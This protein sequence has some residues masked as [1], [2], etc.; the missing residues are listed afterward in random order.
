MTKEELERLKR[1]LCKARKYALAF[2][3]VDDGGTCC[4]DT[5]VIKLSRI[6]KAQ[7]SELPIRLSK[8]GSR[9][10]SGCYF[11]YTPLYGQGFRRTIMAEAAAKSLK[12]DGWDAF[13]YYMMD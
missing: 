9:G 7:L 1:S 12:E 10:W 4:F 13:V 6:T 3:T 5:A 2:A 11:V 8:V